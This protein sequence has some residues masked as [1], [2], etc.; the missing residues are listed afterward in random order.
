MTHFNAAREI[1]RAT[2]IGKRH[3]KKIRKCGE[4]RERVWFLS[5]ACG[6]TDRQT[7]THTDTLNHNTTVGLQYSTVVLY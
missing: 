1:D 5:H 3:R 7:H 6:Q 2:A 4:V